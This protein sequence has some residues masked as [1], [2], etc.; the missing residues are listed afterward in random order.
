MPK[1]R[2]K[3]DKNAKKRASEPGFALLD[4]QAVTHKRE[5]AE[6]GNYSVD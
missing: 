3:Q 5:S 4:G 2:S 1:P 6:D